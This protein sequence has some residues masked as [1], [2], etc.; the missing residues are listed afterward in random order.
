MMQAESL[1]YSSRW[2]R[3]RIADAPNTP[4]L[5]GNAVN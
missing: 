5:K 1:P 4:T 2:H 3:H